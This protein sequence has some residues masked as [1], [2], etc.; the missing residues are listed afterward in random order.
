MVSSVAGWP[1]T[2]YTPLLA[3]M[4][5]PARV[6]AVCPVIVYVPELALSSA[7]RRIVAVVPVSVY[8]PLSAE[9]T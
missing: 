4:S 5:L 2:L 9:R 7:A 8:T 1:V 6:D 3:L